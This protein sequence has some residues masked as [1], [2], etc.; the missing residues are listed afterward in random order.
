[1]FNKKKKKADWSSGM[2]AS[3]NLA[4]PPQEAWVGRSQ[5]LI[6]T[7]VRFLDRPVL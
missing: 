7:Q 3:N 6:L 1:M 2:T 4:A 5:S